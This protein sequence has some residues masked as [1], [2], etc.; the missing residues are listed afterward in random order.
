MFS[1]AAPSMVSALGDDHVARLRHREVRLGGHDHAEGLQVG[2]GLHVAIP[3]LIEGKFAKIVWT[4]LRR[5]G[6]EH[7]SQVFQAELGGWFKAGKPGINFEIGLLAFDLGLAAGALQQ[8]GSL[9]IDL[10]DPPCRR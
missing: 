3:I 7:V 1:V 8:V 5:Y 9:E 4:P 6:P 10:G 2:E